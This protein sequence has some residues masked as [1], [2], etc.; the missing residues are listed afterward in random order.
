MPYDIEGLMKKGAYEELISRKMV[1]ENS[2]S[3]KIICYIKEHHVNT[4]E[5]ADCLNKTGAVRG[6]VPLTRGLFCCGRV[7]YIYAF[8]DS[9]WPVHEQIAAMPEGAIVYV[10]AIGIA[11]RAIFGELVTR[12]L[13]E[14]KKAPAIVTG[15]LLRDAEELRTMKA[16]VWCRGFTPEGCFNRKEIITAEAEAAVSRGRDLYDNAVA[17]C[18]DCGAVLIPRNC[19]N[20]EM[21]EKLVF[22]EERERT[23]FHC[24][25][26]LDWNTYDT[27]CMK[28]YKETGQTEIA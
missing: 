6:A 8:S 3:D 14:K 19:V 26:D 23:W 27:V 5:V 17:V 1:P 28:K 11:E 20:E 22:M 10:D 16:P 7:H 12:F 25:M 18:D 15:G 2:V 21:L 9:N 13:I 4:S 24:V